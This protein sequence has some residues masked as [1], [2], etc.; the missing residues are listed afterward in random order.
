MAH[1]CKGIWGDQALQPA[2]RAV[3]LLV[4]NDPTY[5]Q[6]GRTVS[7]KLRATLEA[8]QLELGCRG[9]PM[10]KNFSQQGGLATD[11]WITSVWERVWSHNFS[12]YLD[13]PVQPF[14]RDQDGEI[15]ELLLDGGQ[16]SKALKG[17][18]RCRL[19]HKAI[20]L[21]CISTV[22]GTHIDPRFLQPP[23]GKERLSFFKFP[24]EQPTKED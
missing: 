6:A 23:T 20:Y 1:D 16:R 7:S 24:Q 11:A 12:I 8:L 21:S 17:L 2:S 10:N 3:H 18:N 15:V 9:N 19:V 22:E 14:P 4:G 13:Y 5:Y